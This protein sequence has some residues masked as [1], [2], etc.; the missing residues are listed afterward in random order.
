MSD[1]LY[2]TFLARH[3]ETAW[4]TPQHTSRTDLPLI[5]QDEAEACRLQTPEYREKAKR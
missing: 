3:G 1:A 5:A 4:P 2:L